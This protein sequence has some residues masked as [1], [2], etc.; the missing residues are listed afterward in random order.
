MKNPLS[1]RS[2]FALSLASP[3]LLAC[4]LFACGAPKEET[5]PAPAAASSKPEIRLA[6]LKEIR[7]VLGEPGAPL[8]VN[9]WA[10][11]CIPC[12]QEMPDLLQGTRDFRA[13]GGKLIGI[14][15]ERI[16]EG[17]TEAAVMSE[18]TRVAERLKLDFPILVC[19]E[20][21]LLEVRLILN[22]DLGGLPQTFGYD[23]KG[24][25]LVHHEGTATALEFQ[26]IAEQIF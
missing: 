17:S 22:V 16:A 3:C 12:M 2:R 21:D 20:D 9:F 19:T 14:A 8:I 6:T 18:V 10:T 4:L 26:Q 5:P 25:L 24:R 15:L 7:E 11:W 23:R 13:K 1:H